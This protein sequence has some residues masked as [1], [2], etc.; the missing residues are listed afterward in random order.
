MKRSGLTGREGKIMRMLFSA[1]LSVFMLSSVLP[2][3][4]TAEEEESEYSGSLGTEEEVYRGDPS[5]DIPVPQEPGN[6]IPLVIVNVDEQDLH[7]AAD[8]H[9]YGTIED[10]N[11]SENHSVRCKG[12]VTIKV[13]EG[14]EGFYGVDTAPEGELTL[15]YIRG[16]GNTTWGSINGKPYKIKFEKGQDLFGM[17]KSKEYAL[18]ANS[19]DLTLMKNRIA[20][21]LGDA[22]GLKFTPQM[23]PVDVV[24]RG[25]RGTEMYLGSYCLS[26]LVDVGKNR[27]NIKEIDQDVTSEDEADDPNITGGYLIS[28]YTDSQ[29]GDEPRNVVFKTDAG[30]EMFIR[31]PEYEGDT[32]DTLSEGEKKQISYIKDYIQ[33]LEDLIMKPEVID[34]ETHEQIASMMDLTSAADYW[35]VQEFTKNGDGFC[36]S[37]TYMY[38]DRNGKL[39]WGPLWDFDIAL[40]DQDDGTNT[41]EEY[42]EEIGYAA[43][44]FD[45][46]LFPWIDDLRDKD[47][48]FVQLLKDRWEIMDE[49]LEEMTKDGGVIDQFLSEVR[50]SA[51]ENGKLW[52]D[53]DY[54]T[55]S[56]EEYE[57]AVEKQKS[58][59]DLRRGWIS[60]NL[61]TIGKSKMILTF[62]VDGEVIAVKKVTRGSSGFDKPVPPE[63]EG[64]WFV[65]WINEETSDKIDECYL[66]DDTTFI[67]YYIKKEDAVLPE[68]MYLWKYEDR[69]DLNQQIYAENMQVY[70]VPSNVSFKNVTWKSSDEKIASVRQNGDVNLLGT[71]DVVL[72]AEHRSGA[73]VSYTLH[74]YDSDDPANKPV[75]VTGIRMDEQLTIKK[76]EAEQISWKL[77]PENEII[78][79]TSV[80]FESEDPSIA[81]VDDYF[82]VVTGMQPGTTTVKVTVTPDSAGTEAV[83]PF[84]V[85]C[86]ITV[87]GEE[88][89]APES[90]SITP[91]GPLEIPTLQTQQLEVTAVPEGADSR[92]TWTSSDEKVAVV[93]ENGVVTAKTYGK[94]VIT[95]SSVSDPDVKAEVTVQTRFHDVID[96][97]QSYY[98]PVYWGADNGV[99]AGFDKGV[100]FGPD[101]D[102]TRAQFVTFL[103]RL[104]GRPAGTKDVS[105]P[106]VDQSANYFRAVKWAV[107]QGI[108]VGFK[109]DNAPATFEPDG[110]VTRGQVATMLWRYGGRK[111]AKT[112]ATFS[113]VKSTDNIYRA[114]SWGQEAGIIKGYKSGEYA[115]QF[116]PDDSCLRQHIVTFLYRYDREIKKGS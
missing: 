47:P 44:N 17:G 68:K 10:M 87:T 35:L 83:D 100:Y 66:K 4:I 2:I 38:K 78:P 103:W 113:D 55:H 63:K 85:T 57:L 22:V 73:S 34:A 29:N 24:L 76:G 92:V 107:S 75:D 11:N 45:T 31:V 112:G 41:I 16:R 97:S 93:D 42:E 37:S 82:G 15:S 98:K 67:P 1:V 60:D 51:V 96:S 30:V 102:C 3:T 21:W 8:G 54:C 70:I 90:I 62:K 114:V 115:G 27:V 105:F 32:E 69:V 28:I 59:I 43:S 23:I 64:Y 86:E 80:S 36:T 71:G 91:E 81:E 49:K 13:P 19:R 56:E 58:W 12:T 108:I 26:E 5:P 65:D 116:R 74:I 109:H 106:D 104:A 88:A 39:C 53:A 77:L 18:M 6:G 52:P 94:A 79:Y 25:S 110:V 46:I 72:T 89:S 33:T 95:A 9:Q 40:G 14:Y 99:V 111:T 20:S 48:Q 101:E 50:A 7:T 61:D 84:T